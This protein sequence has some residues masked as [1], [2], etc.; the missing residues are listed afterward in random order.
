MRGEIVGIDGLERFELA[1]RISGAV[2]LVIRDAELAARIARFG[3]LRNDIFE[4]GD[5]LVAVALA[6]LD[7]GQVVKCARIVGFESES[8]LKQR[9]RG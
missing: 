3:I 8:L 9:A 7:Q 5:F 6:A 2:L 1:A 4:I